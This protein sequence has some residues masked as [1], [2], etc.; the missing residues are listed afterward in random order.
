MD[1]SP[2]PHKQPYFAQIEIQSPTPASTP[3]EEVSMQS[4]PPR[5]EFVEVPRPP[6]GVEYADEPFLPLLSQLIFSF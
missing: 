4:S 1:I 5:P 3:S 2:L 6:Q